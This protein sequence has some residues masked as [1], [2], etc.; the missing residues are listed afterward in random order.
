MI[1]KYLLLLFYL[2]FTTN[3]EAWDPNEL[4][5]FQNT[6]SKADLLMASCCV[7]L[8]WQPQTLEAK[9][10]HLLGVITWLGQ[11]VKQQLPIL[12]FSRCESVLD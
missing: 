10:N 7:F 12:I 9:V 11:P 1:M 5:V 8:G 4:D 2:C 6:A 3:N